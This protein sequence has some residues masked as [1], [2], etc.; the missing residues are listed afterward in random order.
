[1]SPNDVTKQP[2]W[3]QSGDPETENLAPTDDLQPG[4]IGAHITI[5]SPGPGGVPVAGSTDYFV[6][7]Y[8]KVEVDSAL[9]AGP[10][11]YNGCVAYWRDESKYRVTTDVTGRRGQPAG[12]LRTA[13]VPG[14]R[15]FIQRTGPGIVKIEDA[16]TAEPTTEGLFVIPGTTAGKADCLAAGTA[17]SYP[18]LG[19]SR[20]APAGDR[21]AI[22][23]LNV[24]N[25][26]P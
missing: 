19:T 25:P 17:A 13:V 22:V 23:N 6:K 4:A 5:K 18:I 14:Y 16:P 21:T 24:G 9:G 20:G 11:P 7:S 12:I 3:I 8:Q 26:I 1:M 10:N 15:C 2:L